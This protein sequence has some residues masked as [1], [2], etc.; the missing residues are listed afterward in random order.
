MGHSKGR[1]RRGKQRTVPSHD[2]MIATLH[3]V[4][5]PFPTLKTYGAKEDWSRERVLGVGMDASRSAL[6]TSP[7][8]HTSKSLPFFPPPHNRISGAAGA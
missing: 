5:T 7:L 2:S 1:E 4:C 3:L 8:T 6:I